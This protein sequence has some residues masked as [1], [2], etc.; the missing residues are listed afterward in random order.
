MFEVAS[1]LLNL[2]LST[3]PNLDNSYLEKY[4]SPIRIAHEV[5]TSNE[6]GGTMHIEPND[7]PIVGQ[8]SRV[9]IALTRRG[10]EI[11][12]YEKCD[13][14]L[15]VRSLTDKNIKF[16][17]PKSASILD[18]YLG[19]PSIEV[20]FPQVGRYELR[21]SGSPKEGEDFSAFEL[22]FTTNVGK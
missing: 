14:R 8:K 3:A 10:G 11:I 22:T 12:P 13:C 9:W 4:S 2:N 19:L 17:V 15:E 7:R 20:T 16:T 21:L 6:V 18:R 1:I 5:R